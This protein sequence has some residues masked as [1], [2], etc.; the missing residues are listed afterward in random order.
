V[1]PADIR[2]FVNRDWALI[3]QAKEDQWLEQSREMT[4]SA[5]IQLAAG[6]FQ[7]VKAVKPDWPNP[8]EREADLASHF[9]VLEL[10]RRVAEQ[11]TR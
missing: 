6:L 10:L 9:R 7:Y 4:P 3:E 8:E 2:A 11:H 5:A 1:D